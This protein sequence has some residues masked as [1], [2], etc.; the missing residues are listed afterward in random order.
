MDFHLQHHSQKCA[1]SPHRICCFLLCAQEYRGEVRK[2]EWA[3]DKCTAAFA[4][5]NLSQVIDISIA[6]P[7]NKSEEKQH[8]S[9]P[10][11][12]IA[13]WLL[14]TKSFYGCWIPLHIICQTTTGKTLVLQ[15]P[16]V[17]K[18]QLHR[19]QTKFARDFITDPFQTRVWC[20]WQTTLLP[21]S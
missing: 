2:S 11:A 1:S 16:G 20:V 18:S 10:K 17:Y 8:T 9:N 21:C 5:F 15:L 14:A 19:L 7:E 13:W 6:G 4:R 3:Q 12:N